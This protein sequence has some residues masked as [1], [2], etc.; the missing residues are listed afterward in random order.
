MSLQL[1]WMRAMSNLM[2]G[3]VEHENQGVA[4]A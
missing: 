2:V 1:Y 4:D 3:E